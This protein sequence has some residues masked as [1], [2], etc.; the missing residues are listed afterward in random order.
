MTSINAGINHL[1]E[2]HQTKIEEISKT[3]RKIVFKKEERTQ[4]FQSSDE[5]EVAS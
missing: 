2:Y 3:I 1:E 5:V 4:S